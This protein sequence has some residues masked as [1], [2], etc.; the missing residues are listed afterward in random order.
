MKQILAIIWMFLLT[1]FSAVTFAQTFPEKEKNCFQYFNHDAATRDNVNAY[2]LSYLSRIVYYQYLNVDNNYNLGPLDTSR[3][4]TKYIERTRHFFV[5]PVT[6][7]T[8]T[9]PRLQTTTQINTSTANLQNLQLTQSVQY[10]WVWRSDGQGKNPEA[11]II[12][13]PKSVFVVFRGTDRVDGGKNG[14]MGGSYELGEWIFT[15]NMIHN[16]NVY[17]SG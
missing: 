14:I 5:P 10:E 6:T 4:R 15:D 13:T 3:F 1:S 16:W 2:L 8:T 7:Q 17:G 12:S 11:M 9:E